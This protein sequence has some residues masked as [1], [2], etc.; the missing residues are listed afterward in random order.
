[1]MSRQRVEVEGAEGGLRDHLPDGLAVPPLSAHGLEETGGEIDHAKVRLHHPQATD[2][3]RLLSAWGRRPRLERPGPPGWKDEE[4]EKERIGQLIDAVDRRKPAGDEGEVKAPRQERGDPGVNAQGEREQASRVAR[5]HEDDG[6]VRADPEGQQCAGQGWEAW[7]PGIAQ[8]VGELPGNDSLPAV[9]REEIARDPGQMN[10]QEHRQPHP[11]PRER[12]NRHRA[13]ARV[14]RA[15][16]RLPEPQ[17]RLLDVRTNV[18]SYDVR[19]NVA[20]Y[21]ER[22]LGRAPRRCL[23][24]VGITHSS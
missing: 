12:A 5:E 11:E 22:Q 4:I 2:G 18:A 7:H 6:R 9:K 19:T 23:A 20:S 15:R 21:S 17:G 8:K 24:I 1:G 16:W 10:E 3:D 14:D 13:E